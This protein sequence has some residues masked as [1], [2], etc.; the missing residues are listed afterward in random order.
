MKLLCGFEFKDDSRHIFTDAEIKPIIDT[1]VELGFRCKYI[2]LSAK[3]ELFNDIVFIDV[4]YKTPRLF[5]D[6]NGMKFLIP[7]YN[8][9]KPKVS[10]KCATLCITSNLVREN[11][12]EEF[13]PHLSI[14][15]TLHGS[16][17]PY[18]RKEK[19]LVSR[20]AGMVS[21]YDYGTIED[22]LPT[23]RSN[24][25]I[26]KNCIDSGEEFPKKKK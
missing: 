14:S 21:I 9:N 20:P 13:R 26:L 23:L 25:T 3:K 10:T 22:H 15:T 11:E 8:R 17:W 4:F 2:P 19:I 16:C 18:G 24:M 6:N 5:V 1:L 7:N 12:N